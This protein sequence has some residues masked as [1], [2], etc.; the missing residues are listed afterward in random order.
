MRMTNVKRFCGAG[1]ESQ[2]YCLR[3]D[4]R[5]TLGQQIEIAL[6]AEDLM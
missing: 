5:L 6:N 4:Q 2:R 3:A 1:Y